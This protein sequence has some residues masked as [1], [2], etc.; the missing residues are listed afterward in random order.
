MTIRLLIAL[1][2]LAMTADAAR[3]DPI[4]LLVGAIT[5]IFSVGSLATAVVGLG[6]SIGLNL[7]LG[8]FTKK[9]TSSTLQDQSSKFNE[10]QSIPAVRVIV[11]KTI[12]GGALDFEEVIAPYL[13]MQFLCSD[14]PV[15]GPEKMWI[16]TKEVPFSAISEGSALT[17]VSRKGNPAYQTRL[18]VSFGYGADDQAIDPIIDAAFVNIGSDFRQRGVYRVTMRCDWG[19]NQ[20]EYTSL[21]GQSQRP[22]PLWLSYGIRVYDPRDPTQDAD[23]ESTWQWS[24]NP[25]LHIFHYARS[26]FGGRLY[27]S[28]YDWDMEKVKESADWD[29]GLVGCKDGT[30]IKRYT[31]NGLYTLAET[32]SEVLKK[33]QSSNRSKLID[34]GGKIWIQAAKPRDPVA[35]I[36]DG[37]IVGGFE[38]SAANPKRDTLNNV[39]TRFVANDREYQ[40]VDGPLYRDTDF[41]TADNEK[42]LDTIELEFTDDHRT[43]QRMAKARLLESRVGGALTIK[44][45]IVL[46]AMCSDELIGNAVNVSSNLFS[47]INGTYLVNKVS[48]NEATLDLDLSRYDA[49][50]ET[51]WIPATDEQDFTLPSLDVS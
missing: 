30:F 5:S 31:C 14:G 37:L 33:L 8:A 2:A 36:H 44:V 9:S 19:A 24:D 7:L 6:I 25:T 38:F 11:G 12:H 47:W 4:S 10:R 42:L 1:A 17:P 22:N 45:D 23:D 16:G 32:P 48:I 40:T 34:S 13:Y 20:D 3:A 28:V 41:E 27:A 29:D 49:T 35:T 51:N 50:I 18:Q 39:A 43:A 46:L 26:E 21:W 15:L